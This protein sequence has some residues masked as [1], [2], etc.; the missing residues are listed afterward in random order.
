MAT[1]KRKAMAGWWVEIVCISLVPYILTLVFQFLSSA[2]IDAFELICHGEL[3]LTASIISITT[4]SR[5]YHYKKTDLSLNDLLY[6]TAFFSS[7]IY[8]GT[9]AYIKAAASANTFAVVF[10]SAVCPIAAAVTSYFMEAST[11]GAS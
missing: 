9:F 3:V 5:G 11:K 1:V 2:S 8:V 6:F 10:V 4:A 7:V